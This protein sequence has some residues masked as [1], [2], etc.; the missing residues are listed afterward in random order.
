MNKNNDFILWSLERSSK[1]GENYSQK[2]LTGKSHGLELFHALLLKQPMKRAWNP[3]P[4]EGEN[5]PEN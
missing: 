5:N 3:I 1:Q 2:R 4:H